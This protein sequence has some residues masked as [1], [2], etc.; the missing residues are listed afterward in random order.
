MYLAKQAN[1]TDA[2]IGVN[3]YANM[4][5]GADGLQAFVKVMLLV[6]LQ[7]CLGQK[8]LPLTLGVQRLLVTGKQCALDGNTIRIVPLEVCRVDFG[9]LYYTGL[10][11][12]D[13]YPVI[14]GTAPSRRL[15]TV[16]HVD[17]A[18][19][20][21]EIVHTP[22]MLVA[23]GDSAPAM[24]DSGQVDEA[25]NVTEVGLDFAK[26]PEAGN[27]TVRIDMQPDMAKYPFV[28]NIEVM[29]RIARQVGFGKQFNPVFFGH[30]R[31]AV[32]GLD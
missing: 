10:A 20:G 24:L 12:R 32:T 27:A 14:P 7:F 25:V 19:G 5:Y 1:A 21:G 2:A 30:L 22:I 28:S 29:V 16:P 18:A 13:N 8:R 26:Y 31:I 9:A 23:A 4:A 6:H 11:E 15:P 3:R 17:A